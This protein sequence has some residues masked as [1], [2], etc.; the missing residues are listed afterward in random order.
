MPLAPDPRVTP[1]MIRFINECEKLE[2]GDTGALFPYADKRGYHNTVKRNQQKWPGDYSIRLADDL[3]GN[4][5][6][7]RAF[8]WIS[9]SARTRG[10]R[11]IMNKYGRRIRDAY[12]RRDPR[13]AGWREVLTQV[14]DGAPEG[15]NVGPG[16]GWYTRTPDMSHDYHH[17]LSKLTAY[18]DDWPTYAGMLSILADEPLSVWRAGHSR[19]LQEGRPRMK[20]LFRVK[21]QLYI[22][23]GLTRR[24]LADK[25]LADVQAV[26]GPDL[27]VDADGSGLLWG[28]GKDVGNPDAFG[29]PAA[30]PATST[31]QVDAAAVAEALGSNAAFLA[32]VA[33]AVNDD[34]SRRGA[35]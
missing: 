25:D 4:L 35:E 19:Y 34:A 28:D 30:A 10:D 33:T 29:V 22:G 31:V 21:G 24:P 11:R 6:V 14:D 17:H 8:D 20:R 12:S 13:Y 27:L 16:G 2:P 9:E 26:W 5:T 1:E 7:C 18:V 3:R 23:D 32:A 15:F